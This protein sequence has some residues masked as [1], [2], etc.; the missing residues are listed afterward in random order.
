MLK[1]LAQEGKF[2]I[3]QSQLFF[4]LRFADDKSARSKNTRRRR[5]TYLSPAHLSLVGLFADLTQLPRPLAVINRGPSSTATLPIPL[6]VLNL[7]LECSD[8]HLILPQHHGVRDQHSPLCLR[9]DS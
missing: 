3:L 9:N 2:E 1:S 8:L 4:R 5:W 7:R 6:S